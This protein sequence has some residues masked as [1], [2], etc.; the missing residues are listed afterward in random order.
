MFPSG[1]RQGVQ[2]HVPETALSA[3]WATG[4]LLYSLPG[5]PQIK[6][7]QKSLCQRCENFAGCGWQLIS[8]FSAYSVG[9]SK[10]AKH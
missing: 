9:S 6:K 3:R 8:S 10:T 4:K 2:L 1:N 7:N 5:P